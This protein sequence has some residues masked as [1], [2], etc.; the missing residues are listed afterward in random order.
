M[1]LQVIGGCQGQT[2]QVAKTWQLGSKTWPVF[3]GCCPE[4]GRVRRDRSAGL[5]GVMQP[6]L[7]RPGGAAVVRALPVPIQAG[8]SEVVEDHAQLDRV[9]VAEVVG[10]ED[11]ALALR[12]A[13]EGPIAAL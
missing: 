13:G 3:G 12:A 10:G 4:S 5:A 7:Q 2:G 9:A 8:G 1:H 11:E 6:P